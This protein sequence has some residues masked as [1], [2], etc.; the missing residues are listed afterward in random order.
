MLNP[1]NLITYAT[2]DS[3][4]SLHASLSRANFADKG[5]TQRAAT[6]A[7]HKGR[8]SQVMRCRAQATA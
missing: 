1:P 4:V 3:C 6:G 2:Q 5:S 7:Q 8:K